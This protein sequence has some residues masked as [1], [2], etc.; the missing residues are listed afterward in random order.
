MTLV[1]VLE[2]VQQ[3]HHHGLLLRVLH[4]LRP[5]GSVLCRF[6]HQAHDKQIIEEHLFPK[7]VRKAMLSMGYK[8]EV[9]REIPPFFEIIGRKPEVAVE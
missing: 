5:G 7:V 8:I 9:F 3:Q 1:D 2:H 4:E 6:P